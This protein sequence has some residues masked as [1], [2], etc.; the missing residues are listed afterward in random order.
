[1]LKHYP[2]NWPQSMKTVTKIINY[3]YTYMYLVIKL[4]Q[5]K[6]ETKNLGPLGEENAYLK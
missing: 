5:H 1:M 2:K 3:I 4:E 6:Q